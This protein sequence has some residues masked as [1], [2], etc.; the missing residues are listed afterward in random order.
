M[1]FANTL[2]TEAIPTMEITTIHTDN[3]LSIHIEHFFDIQELEKVGLKLNETMLFCGARHYFNEP[4]SIY[5]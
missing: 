5:P 2:V 3:E 4:Q 1:A